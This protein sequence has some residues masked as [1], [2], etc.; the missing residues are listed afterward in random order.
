MPVDS[1]IDM[2][3]DLRPAIVPFEMDYDEASYKRTGIT[4][5]TIDIPS[6]HRTRR[7]EEY[8]SP[9]RW[10][11]L[12]F[13]FYYLVFAVVLPM[14]VWIPVQLSKGERAA[15]VSGVS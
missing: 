7:P 4:K 14:W 1:V 10:R 2:P 9:P 11:T 13:A 5:L 12:E 15:N 6:S 3:T 8:R